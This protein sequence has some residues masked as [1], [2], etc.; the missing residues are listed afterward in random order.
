[1]KR[2]FLKADFVG[3]KVFA[4]ENQAIAGP[5]REGLA[6][7]CLRKCNASAAIVRRDRLFRLEW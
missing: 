4:P 1:M 7:R 2:S 3:E 5:M 6:R